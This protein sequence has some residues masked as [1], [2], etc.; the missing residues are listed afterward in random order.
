M[1]V[2]YVSMNGAGKRKSIAVDDSS[3]EVGECEKVKVISGV[4]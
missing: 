4:F 1:Y 3:Y 2:T